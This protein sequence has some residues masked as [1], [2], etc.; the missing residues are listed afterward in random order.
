MNFDQLFPDEREKGE[1]RIKQC[2]A[3][4][5]RMFKILDYLCTKHNIQ[6]FLCSGTLKAAI[7]YRGFKPWDDDLDVGMTREN[8]EKFVKYAV[9][10]LP[11]DIFFQ[12]PETDIYFPACH[13]VEAKLRDKYSSYSLLEDQKDC[14]YHT[15]LMLDILVFDKAY[16]PRNFFIFLL[17]RTLKF[18]F[19]KKGNNKRANVLKWIAKYSP[20]PL[21]YSNSYIDGRAMIKKGANYFRP[22]ELS[23]FIKTKFENVEAYIPEGYDDYLTRKYGNYWETPP[24]EKQK[25]HHSAET[26]DPFTPCNHT[27]ILHWKNRITFNSKQAVNSVF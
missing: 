21:V 22:K 10:E 17:N 11:Y 4:L 12:T 19:K 26:P 16:L 7:R 14:Q 8:Y 23:K 2:H 3:V 24:P 6:Y 15:G 20:F 13:R 25:G 27:A 5:L 9:P 1:T 18:F